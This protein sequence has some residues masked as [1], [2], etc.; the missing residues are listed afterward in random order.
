LSPVRSNKDRVHQVARWLAAEFQTPYPV[1]VRCVKKIAADR[2]DSWII[3]KTGYYGEN[4]RV[5]RQI[6]IRIAVRPSI[7]RC[8]I[9]DTLLHEWAHAVT[10]RHDVI[11]GRR[12]EHGGHDDEWGL[13][14]GKIYRC[15]VDDG[16]CEVSENY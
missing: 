10:M 7:N 8:T 13:A 6:I 2:G 4:Y 1:T 11:E 14:H 16:G 12:V 3:R 5:G 15:F 9:L